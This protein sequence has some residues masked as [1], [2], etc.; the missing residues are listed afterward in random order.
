MYLVLGGKTRPF[1]EATVDDVAYEGIYNGFRQM[2][3]Y[4]E[5]WNVSGRIVTDQTVTS[6]AQA[7][8]WMSGAINELRNDLLTMVRPRVTMLNDD[9]S[10]S[11]WDLDP[12]AC[13]EGPTI[14]S[15][16]FP[17]DGQDIFVT[18]NNYAFQVVAVKNL[19]SSGAH[20]VLEFNEGLENVAG[21]QINGHV[22]GIINPAEP[23][24]FKQF[25]PWKY[26]QSGS[27]LGQYGFPNIPPPIYPSSM[28]RPVRKKV[29][30]PEIAFPVPQR[31]RID[32]SYEFESSVALPLVP[33]HS[34][35]V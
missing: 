18:G 10:V 31:F 9:L 27:A 29:Y 5:I 8:S 13:V 22:G 15:I 30:S 23:Q 1:L 25:E 19:T 21:G 32:W 33:P 6:A 11:C 34:F 28:T 3:Q 16:R 4:R 7:A 35:Y 12:L 17:R 26:I 14:Q 20:G 24:V 2:L